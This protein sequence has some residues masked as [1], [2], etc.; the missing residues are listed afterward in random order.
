MPS[1]IIG[2][3]QSLGAHLCFLDSDDVMKPERVRVQLAASLRFPNAMIGSRVE[4]VPADSTSRYTHWINGVTQRELVTHRF[5]DVSLIA[6]TWFMPR[7]V[8]ASTGGF[9][10]ELAEDLLLLHAHITAFAHQH[11]HDGAQ[12]WSI[13]RRAFRPLDHSTSALSVVGH[14]DAD[15]RDRSTTAEARISAGMPTAE[16]LVL[17]TSE[18]ALYRCPE[19][20]M[21]YRFREASGSFRVSRA[22]L[23]EMRTALLVDQ[24]LTKWPDRFG[25]W[26]AGKNGRQFFQA[27]PAHL[28]ARVRAFYDV[29][30]KKLGK[31]YRHH[32]PVTRHVLR[33]IP[34]LPIEGLVPPFVT[35]LALDRTEGVFEATLAHMAVDLVEGRDYVI[36]N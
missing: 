23:R 24:V 35:C 9:S 4:R 36:F 11:G 27:L 6:P 15:P 34:I 13:A 16:Q 7:R 10:P 5:R 8:F 18:V 26:S 30:A 12:A 31:E 14:T 17:P 33:S 28:Q 22:Y 29:D 3:L 2:A 25:I 1:V 32:D 21:M 19:V 20:L